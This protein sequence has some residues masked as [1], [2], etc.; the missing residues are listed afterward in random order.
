MDFTVKRN[1]LNF[2]RMPEFLK[3]LMPEDVNQFKTILEDGFWRFHEEL[4]IEEQGMPPITKLRIEF[5]EVIGD[6]PQDKHIQC[7]TSAEF[8][9]YW[10]YG[11]SDP[12]TGKRNY[13][14]LIE[15]GKME[16][17]VANHTAD[18]EIGVCDR[19]S[20][21]IT[22][23]RYRDVI[24]FS[25]TSNQLSAHKLYA[26]IVVDGQNMYKREFI[27]SA[28]KETIPVEDSTLSDASLYI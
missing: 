16:F 19:F 13:G 1:K 11:I 22:V 15:D 24:P 7:E 21:K 8:M 26:P 18:L 17:D 27:F 20:K 4:Y 2:L 25:I 23:T 10:L 12:I 9:S 14:G 28:I 6:N 3:V 5:V